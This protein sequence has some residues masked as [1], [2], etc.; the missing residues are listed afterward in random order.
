[1]RI[2]VTL[3]YEAVGNIE[4]AVKSLKAAHEP[5]QGRLECSSGVGSFG[6]YEARCVSHSVCLPDLKGPFD[7]FEEETTRG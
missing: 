7:Q 5:R 4:E 6:R 1:M 2:I 3:I